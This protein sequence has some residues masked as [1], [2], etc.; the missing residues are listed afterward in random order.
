MAIERDIDY[1]MFQQTETERHEITSKLSDDI[2]LVNIREQLTQPLIDA[3]IPNNVLEIFNGR[4]TFIKSYYEDDQ[5]L[6]DR[7]KNI[8]KNIYTDI[9]IRICDRFGIAT[10]LLDNTDTEDFYVYVNAM[11]NFFI[12]NHKKNLINFFIDYIKT[13]KKDLIKNFKNNSEKKDLM[14]KSL[15]KSLGDSDNIHII[16]NIENIIDSYIN[17][18]DSE[19]DIIL[20]TI[21]NT[22]EFEITNNTIKELFA[23]SRFNTFLSVKFIE[24]FF[25]PLQLE[26]YRYE[27][28]TNI[29]NEIVTLFKE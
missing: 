6:I 26:D 24:E 1:D 13:N 19:F 14:F 15:K 16:Y 22:D 7:C 28:I 18:N 21:I 8:R 27:I 17:M 25:R 5:P 4:Y 29:R 9:C 23:E 2:I 20:E 3:I 11:Y 12:I 10:S